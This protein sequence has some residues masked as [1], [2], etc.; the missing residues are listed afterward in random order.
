MLASNQLIVF[1]HFEDIQQI[2]KSYIFQARGRPQG[3]INKTDFRLF[4]K[5]PDFQKY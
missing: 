5:N 2:Q 1:W 4:P 3:N